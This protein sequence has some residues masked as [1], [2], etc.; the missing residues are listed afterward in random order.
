VQRRRHQCLG[1]SRQ[2]LGFRGR[3]GGLSASSR[4]S[5]RA[6][7]LARAAR[8]PSTTLG[9]GWGRRPELVKSGRRDR[10]KGNAGAPHYPP[11]SS[12][13]SVPEPRC[14]TDQSAITRSGRAAT[15]Q[16]RLA[17][18]V[19]RPERIAARF[20]RRPQPVPSRRRQ[21]KRI[22]SARAWRRARTETRFGTCPTRSLGS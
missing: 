12:P 21:Q 1:V 14:L 6:A 3:G 20:P 16:R 7:P 8:L 19:Q 11:Q 15:H 18:M 10:P 22:G 17:T 4:S 5:Y 2:R 9:T 13:I